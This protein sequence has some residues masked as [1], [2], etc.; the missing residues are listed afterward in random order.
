MFSL[1][2]SPAAQT[3][4]FQI[5]KRA[6]DGIIFFE[7]LIAVWL[8]GIAVGGSVALMV[9]SNQLAEV[10]RARVA[11]NELCQARIAQTVAATF[12]PPNKLPSFF[13]SWPIS[14]AN[15]VTST[16]TVQLYTSVDGGEIIPATR[17]T[18]V[19][20]ANASLN[21]VRVTA[22]VSYVYRG[23]NH[24]SAAYTVRSPD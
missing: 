21:L 11:A 20:L 24:V 2:R 5:P 15:T 13:G 1:F 6:V 10:N 17:T 23:K 14:A 12:I 19:S 7:A 18:S 9:T 16:E 3:R 8:I 4:T 22:Q